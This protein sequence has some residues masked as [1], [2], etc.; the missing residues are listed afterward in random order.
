M[1]KVA[2]AGAGLSQTQLALRVGY[3]RSM[4]STVESA[5]GSW[6]SREFWGK[7]D[8]VLDTGG[9][10][11]ACVDEIPQRA[12]G[13]RRPAR[14]A[15]GN[16]PGRPRIPAG[17]RKTTQQD[18]SGV[19]A[20]R[21]VE[22]AAGYRQL[23]WPAEERDGG[24]E[25]V[26]GEVLDAL[27]VSRVAGM[28]AIRWWL[29]TDGVADE[30]RGLPALPSPQEAMAVI[31]A[32]PGMFF[33][34]AGGCCPWR[35][36]DRT[37]G[38]PDDADVPLVRWHASGSRI[39]APPS[40]VAR[41]DRAGWAHFPVGPVRL[42]SPIALLDLLAKAAAMAGRDGDALALPGGVLAVPAARLRT[43]DVMRLRRE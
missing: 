6:A 27:E 9:T 37:P 22:A 3:S 23:G 2:R 18:G 42:A 43:V 35:L 25:L 39:P 20:T 36:S 7:C 4:I 31:E 17:G 30:I 1:L 40:Q 24:L 26:S 12:P 28:L 16:E 5:A 13:P 14:G 38:V 19:L 33:V 8:Q 11:T 34:T 10:L 29:Y 15:G 41:H 21:V 32:G